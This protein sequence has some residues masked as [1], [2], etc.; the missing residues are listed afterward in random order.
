MCKQPLALTPAQRWWVVHYSDGLI[1]LC[2]CIAT[3]L[4]FKEE[5]NTSFAFLFVATWLQPA[6]VCV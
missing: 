5:T 1:G 4:V 6:L 3:E 2:L